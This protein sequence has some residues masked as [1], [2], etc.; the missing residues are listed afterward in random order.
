[1]GSLAHTVLRHACISLGVCGGLCSGRGELAFLS[2][3]LLFC[4]QADGME[5][6]LQE[7]YGMENKKVWHLVGWVWHLVG[8]V[9]H[10]GLA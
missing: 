8:W 9:W 7:I 10:L 6:I 2:V 3:C 4:L 1:M 5:V